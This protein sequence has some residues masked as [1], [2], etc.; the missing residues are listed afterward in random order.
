MHVP[1]L[2]SVTNLSTITQYWYTVLSLRYLG[3]M[4]D[5]DLNYI[6]LI[7]TEKLLAKN[8]ICSTLENTSLSS[9][10][11]ASQVRQ[12]WL[13]NYQELQWYFL[14]KNLSGH[15]IWCK[16]ACKSAFYLTEEELMGKLQVIIGERYSFSLEYEAQSM[17]YLS[18]GNLAILAWKCGNMFIKE[19]KSSTEGDEAKKKNKGVMG[20]RNMR[21]Q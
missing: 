18:N 3:Y 5:F 19:I 9:S 10:K 16:L 6:K 12:S 20:Q 13:I 17:L 1:V 14:D 7:Q 2:V 4:S 11:L 15:H 21:F 8:I